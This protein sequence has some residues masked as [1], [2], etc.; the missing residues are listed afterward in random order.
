MSIIQ[1]VPSVNYHLWQ[2]CNMKCGFCF[3]AFDDVR[4]DVL[5]KGHLPR[6]DSIE[7]VR[8][9][10][11]AGF[12]KINFAGG[13]PLLCPWLPELIT[14]AHDLGMVTSIV[15]NGTK[16]TP[17][18]LDSVHGKLDWAALSVDSINEKTNRNIGRVY[19]GKVFSSAYFLRLVDLLRSGGVRLKINTV[20]CSENKDEVLSEFI[21]SAMPERWKI[22]QVLPVKGQNDDRAQE[23]LVSDDDFLRY[24]RNNES[25][26]RKGVVMVPETNDDMT[27]SYFMVDPAGRFFDN[28]SG[29]YR[30]SQSIASVG[31]LAAIDQVK[32]SAEKFI[33]RAGLYAW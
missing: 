28:S 32:M 15:T 33:A 30:Y 20:V 4:R 17:H 1:R 7:I 6:L 2:P 26:Q 13:E 21:E 19:Q 10:A 31:V 11:G 27:D 24:L 14:Q 8:L 16:L 29:G 3:A 9:L 5:P 18:W 23:M 25:V 12:K 22:F